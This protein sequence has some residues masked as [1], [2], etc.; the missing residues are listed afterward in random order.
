[1]NNETNSYSAF[2]IAGRIHN[3]NTIKSA[4][5]GEDMIQLRICGK[6]QRY[7]SILVFGNLVNQIRNE[8][9]LNLIKAGSNKNPFVFVHGA[10]SEYY[11]KK[12]DGKGYN[13]ISLI[14]SE[15]FF[16]QDNRVSTEEVLN[17]MMDDFVD[18]EVTE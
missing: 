4:T 16:C 8:I 13:E 12:S 1:M 11:R 14:A 15:I 18:E 2:Q 6:K 9:Q 10:I 7:V 5:S 3:I 17:E